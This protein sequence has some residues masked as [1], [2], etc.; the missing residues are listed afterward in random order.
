LATGH[1]RRRRV[2]CDL[3]LG[4]KHCSSNGQTLSCAEVCGVTAGLQRLQQ[5]ECWAELFFWGKI[6]GREKDYFIAYGIRGGEFSTP[7]KHFYWASD[8]F[9][10]QAFDVVSDQ[11]L[12]VIQTVSGRLSGNPKKDL[13][14]AEGEEPG[15]PAEGEEQKPS[16]FESKRLA[17]LVQRID[18]DTACVPQG[19]Y[20]LDQNHELIANPGFQGL[21]WDE[22]RDLH[23]YQH[24][25]VGQDLASVRAVARDDPEFQGG[26]LDSLGMDLPKQCWVT[27]TDPGQQA[28]AL[29][30]LL[31]PGY[32]AFH[33][34]KTG[35]FGG[36]Y[37][38][39]GEKCVDLPFLL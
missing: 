35:S 21:S 32:T 8:S 13:T 18:Q 14:L 37:I 20:V 30:S 27:R 22:A 1:Y 19:S 7:Q 38:G 15:E 28:V 3:D 10:F 23:C 16:V 24:L 33:I 36:V 39:T 12:A 6:I 4:L 5:A 26:C 11:D 29:R 34:P 17:D 31:W 25:R 2:H 9:E